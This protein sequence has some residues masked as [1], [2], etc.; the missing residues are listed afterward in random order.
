MVHD[1]RQKRSGSEPT[2]NLRHSSGV[3]GEGREWRVEE[4]LRIG[5]AAVSGE[6]G[7]RAFDVFDPEGRY[8]GMLSLPFP[9]PLASN[10]EPIIRD[11]VLHG[12]TSDESGV[13]YVV[14]A[15]IVKPR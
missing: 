9:L 3:K 12:V 2:G 6:D 14:R 15:R 5:S 1:Y 11:G 4:E 10:P 8:L 13:P 7:G